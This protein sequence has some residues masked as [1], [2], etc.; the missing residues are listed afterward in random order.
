MSYKTT[1]AYVNNLTNE[2]EQWN[3]LGPA[4]RVNVCCRGDQQFHG[5][6][7]YL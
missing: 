4:A 3:P 6:F 1:D 7:P 5:M 2:I